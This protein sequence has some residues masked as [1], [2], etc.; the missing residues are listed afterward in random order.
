M[1]RWP[2]AIA[3][4]IGSQGTT[5]SRTADFFC[6]YLSGIPLW[7]HRP[8][9]ADLN[10][11]AAEQNESLASEVQ[12]AHQCG[13]TLVGFANSPASF[14]VN[15]TSPRDFP[16]TYAVRLTRPERNRHLPNEIR[17]VPREYV[18]PRRPVLPPNKVTFNPD[19]QTPPR[20]L[21][22]APWLG[23]ADS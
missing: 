10:R 1:R 16:A 22:A 8:L 6:P 21:E 5:I 4:R 2:Q 9:Q 11:A 19:T 17:Q 13:S 23:T 7:H 12:M 20:S 14:A 3:L 15:T 18:S